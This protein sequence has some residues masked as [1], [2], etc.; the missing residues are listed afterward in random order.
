MFILQPRHSKTT[1]EINLKLVHLERNSQH[2]V[3]RNN[4][5]KTNKISSHRLSVLVCAFLH[6]AK[7]KTFYSP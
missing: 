1:R 6:F 3:V 5:S 4:T 7:N 2:V